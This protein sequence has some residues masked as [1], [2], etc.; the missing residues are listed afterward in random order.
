MIP[1]LAPKLSEKHIKL[2]PFSPMRVCLAAQVLSN[3]V[4]KEILTHVT[5]NDMPPAATFTADFIEKMDCLFNI[6]NSTQLSDAMIFKRALT[7]SFPA[8]EFLEKNDFLFKKSCFPKP[9][10]NFTIVCERMDSKY[11][12]FKTVME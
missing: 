10:K 1:R 9:K 4:S 7:D 8:W 12:C 5:L 6:F 3:S 2:P 11:F